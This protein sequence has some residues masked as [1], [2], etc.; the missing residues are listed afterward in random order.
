MSESLQD[1]CESNL[2]S[3]LM[4]AY[5]QL[6]YWW[7]TTNSCPCGARKE[8]PTAHPHVGGCPTAK[9]IESFGEKP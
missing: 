6:F 5:Q 9:A 8:S 3:N 2:R 4:Q 1:R 7:I